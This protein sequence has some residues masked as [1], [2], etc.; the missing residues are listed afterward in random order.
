MIKIKMKNSLIKYEIYKK[1]TFIIEL[2]NLLNK[3]RIQN[4]IKSNILNSGI[5]YRRMW[6][7]SITNLQSKYYLDRGKWTDFILSAE[8]Y[9]ENNKIKINPFTIQELYSSKWNISL[10]LFW[11][12]IANNLNSET[13]FKF[14]L[15]LSLIFTTENL[16]DE[17]NINKVEQIRSIGSV[18]V[19]TN[20][21]FDE[22]LIYF[23]YSLE[24]LEN[25]YSSFFITNVILTFNICYDD[26][27]LKKIKISDEIYNL[28]NESQTSKKEMVNKSILKLN[29]KNLPV[30]TNLNE[31]GNL[32]IIKG[33]YLYKFNLKESK[34]IINTES[35]NIQ[36]QLSEST[37]SFNYIVSI[38]GLYINGK[39]NK[40]STKERVSVTDKKLKVVV[41]NFTDIVNNIQIPNSFVRIINDSQ[42]VYEKGIRVLTQKRKKTKYFTNL[43]TCKTFKYKFITMDL[44]TK[45]INGILTPYCVSI[46]DGE[47]SYSFYITDFNS[48]EEMLKS[49]IL[50]ILK[51]K[52]K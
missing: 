33:D 10:L 16:K 5:K 7:N 2:E 22:A 12:D 25:Q 30:T 37:E 26:S 9:I 11:R 50:F 27:I 46:F 3:I 43:K 1:D 19:Y 13:V 17:Q 44:E 47:K 14:Q 48:S 18:K 35:K 45:N 4:E 8:K 42:Y 24:L 6:D 49:S 29:E 41:L 52:Y 38:R 28:I 39:K 23:K 51:R 34:V 20:K 32:N 21:N 31:W 36:S 40:F 15:K